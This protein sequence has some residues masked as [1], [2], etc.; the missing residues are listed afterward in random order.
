[1][2]NSNSGSNENM[3][4]NRS[5]SSNNNNTSRDILL[6]LLNSVNRN[7]P[8]ARINGSSPLSALLANAQAG[9]NAQA[10]TVA[11]SRR[12]Q[13][14]RNVRR[15]RANGQNA[16][17]NLDTERPSESM[18]NES[19]KILR[20]CA[21][22]CIET[23]K[24]FI[25]KK[26]KK[27]QDAYTGGNSPFGGNGSKRASMNNMADENDSPDSISNIISGVRDIN[28]N[29]H[30]TNHLDNHTDEHIPSYDNS[31][32]QMQ[33]KSSS[34]KLKY[35]SNGV[36]IFDKSNK[37]HALDSLN[38]S[39]ESSLFNSSAENSD[40]EIDRD[41]VRSNAA[42]I[43]AGLDPTTS[44][45]AKFMPD[46]TRLTIESTGVHL[47]SDN[48][49]YHSKDFKDG[50]SE[51]NSVETIPFSDFD[52]IDFANDAKV[53]AGRI[54][55]LCT[56]L[57]LIVP[58][59]VVSEVSKISSELISDLR[60]LS[61]LLGSSIP[62]EAGFHLVEAMR[63]VARKLCN[64]ILDL[65]NY[66]LLPDNRI[67]IKMDS[68]YEENGMQLFNS[69]P[70]TESREYDGVEDPMAGRSTAGMRTAT[71]IVWNCC[72][73]II[74]DK[75]LP[76]NNLVHCS[77][78]IDIHALLIQDA[79]DELR[80]IVR[81]RKK[82]KKNETV[83]SDEDFDDAG[84]DLDDDDS[85]NA[86]DWDPEDF[87][88]LDDWS[89]DEE[90]DDEEG[91]D[92]ITDKPTEKDKPILADPE[93]SLLEGSYLLA[94]EVSNLIT[95]CM[96]I[97]KRKGTQLKLLS[98]KKIKTLKSEY[99]DAHKAS[100][101]NKVKFSKNSLLNDED[102]CNLIRFSFLTKASKECC[103]VGDRVISSAKKCS[104]WVDNLAT[105][106]Y[107]QPKVSVLEIARCSS[108][109]TKYGIEMANTIRYI[110]TE[111][112]TLSDDKKEN[113]K[114]YKNKFFL[115][116]KE[117]DKCDDELLEGCCK[118]IENILDNKI[119]IH[120]SSR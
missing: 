104:Q 75:I 3:D 5:N 56:K 24:T 28:I 66:C 15:N 54:R 114:L 38:T 32:S 111:S 13:N 98:N 78:H 41:Y 90:E 23:V 72:D 91:L 115:S 47:S 55:R 101:Q 46:T 12:P 70:A 21:L 52:E 6:N 43:N 9:G 86:D 73:S 107:T 19:Q 82:S 120:T 63:D 88:D 92:G 30:I 96:T 108:E 36:L 119:L 44:S 8:N 68:V 42:A 51:L 10:R 94:S 61:W 80:G 74:L 50:V 53:L 102:I 95:Y 105:C 48:S 103:T 93:L 26:V 99:I 16:N 83:E 34:A 4:S 106:G 59:A 58:T 14:N 112:G 27:E 17:R 100:N 20:S 49:E 117:S 85:I 118:E 31:I 64:A 18:R 113:E 25:P 39:A 65:F 110:L 60:S 11:G 97:L 81:R 109:L 40:T 35:D 79:I 37:K 87:D 67:E 77:T 57:T 2:R 71:A 29:K 1:M 69:F 45:V 33:L 116:L 22:Q 89:D 62:I 76:A 7:S 84:S